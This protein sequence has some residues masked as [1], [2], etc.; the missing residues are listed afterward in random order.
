M[1]TN[2]HSAHIDQRHF[3][4]KPSII[5]IANVCHYQKRASATVP[6]I[7]A[8]IGNSGFLPL[9][10]HTEWICQE[11]VEMHANIRRNHEIACKNTEIFSIGFTTIEWKCWKLLKENTIQLHAVAKNIGKT[12]WKTP[13][14]KKITHKIESDCG[15]CEN[16]SSFAMMKGSSL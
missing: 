2:A 11:F 1:H 10:C 13:W 6:P 9:K 3:W 15:N 7:F 16:G 12:C 4:P 14:E 5:W 8:C